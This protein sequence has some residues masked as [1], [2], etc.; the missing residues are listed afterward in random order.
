SDARRSEASVMS[1]RDEAL[2]EYLL[3]LGDTPLVLAQRLG[4]WV[5]KGPILEEDIASTNVGLDLIG[6]ARLWLSYAGEVEARARG[7]GRD[8]DQL[9]FLRDAGDLRNLLIVEQPNGS[10]ADT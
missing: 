5:G 1:V 2:F 3:R 10:Y 8:E 6:Q 7:G 9:A 4:E